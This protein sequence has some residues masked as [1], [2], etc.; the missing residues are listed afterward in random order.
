[1][2][3]SAPTWS[4]PS[5]RACPEPPADLRL[6]G[7]RPTVFSLPFSGLL[8]QSFGPLHGD[9]SA[10]IFEVLSYAGRSRLQNKLWRIRHKLS[11]R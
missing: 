7:S 11:P 2:S 5:R 9:G 4:R 6:P 10:L 3:N 1:M 8:P